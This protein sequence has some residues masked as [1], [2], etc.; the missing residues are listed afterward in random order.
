M[1]ALPHQFYKEVVFY[2]ILLFKFFYGELLIF[3]ARIILM[4]LLNFSKKIIIK[5]DFAVLL[6]ALFTIFWLAVW[7]V[8]FNFFNRKLLF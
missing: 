3:L 6:S 7:P 5:Y 1:V 8:R 4:T 2:S